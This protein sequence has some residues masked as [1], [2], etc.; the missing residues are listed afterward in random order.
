MLPRG[1]VSGKPSTRNR[2]CWDHC[3]RGHATVNVD[4]LGRRSKQTVAW[5]RVERPVSGQPQT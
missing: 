1:S 5:E 3:L 2:Y 4:Q